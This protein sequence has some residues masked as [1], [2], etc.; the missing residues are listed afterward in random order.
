M[1]PSQRDQFSRAVTIAKR[2]QIC[3]IQGTRHDTGEL[4]WLVQSRSDPR[5]HY[6][7]TAVGEHIQCPCQQAQHHGICAHAAAVRLLLEDEPQPA[8]VVFAQSNQTEPPQAPQYQQRSEFQ[9]EQEQRQRAEAER[10]ER[11]LLWTDDR[12]F[13]IWKA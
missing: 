11:A 4:I 2:D 6:L 10:R 8:A 5:R 9:R 7:I 3:P 13:S 1:N 12:P